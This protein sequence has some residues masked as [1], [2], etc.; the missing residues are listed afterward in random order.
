MTIV[1]KG[2]GGVKVDGGGEGAIVL[3]PLRRACSMTAFRCYAGS[4]RRL[5]EN[6]SFYGPVPVP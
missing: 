2:D 3:A 6:S 4:E 5:T 1:A